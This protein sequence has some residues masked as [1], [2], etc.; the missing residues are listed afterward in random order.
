MRVGMR[1]TLALMIAG[2][3]L[4]AL[5]SA[6]AAGLSGSQKKEISRVA[7][8]AVA[9]TPLPGLSVAV[10]KD[11]QI[12][13]AG[14]GKADLEQD[15]PV[16]AKSMFR[17]ASVAKW[18]TA[19]AAMRL[20]ENG[21]L[22]L[23]APIQ[24]YCPQFPHKRWPITA[25]QLLNHTSGVRHYFGSN[26]EKRETDADRT[27]IETLVQRERA[28]QFTRYTDVIKPLDAFKEDP[29]LFPPGTSAQYTSLGYRVLGCV[30][31]GAAGTPFRTVMS[32]L[33]FV[34]AGMTT[35]V[36]DDAR[37]IVPH[38]VAGYSRGPDNTMLRAEYR[39]VSD[40]VPGGGY[41]ATAED[42]VHFAVAFQS[43][44]L[45]K[46][47]TREQMVERPKLGDG[48][49]APNPLG[50]PGYH[51]GL[52]IMVDGS[53]ARPAW[54]HTGGQAGTTTLLMLF[55]QD[56]LVVAVMTN[57]DGGAVREAL[58]RKIADVASPQ[59]GAGR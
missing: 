6:Y 1:P 2:A 41:L 56:G 22:D 16:T 49:P 39:D 45:V 47:A 19:V 11:G 52:G 29:L 26:G 37:A 40:N 38:R 5:S 3:L 17:T 12:W 53:S 30:I 21:K 54:F 14:F 23:D 32:D 46:D 42:L 8:E 58:V 7:Q 31:Q 43:G 57:L 18:M 27:V 35:I 9:T 55:P 4:A 25:R 15:V 51:Y 44:K 33:V 24:Q 48:T 59:R 13:T 20:V 34:P 36:E 28:T 10:S 50:P